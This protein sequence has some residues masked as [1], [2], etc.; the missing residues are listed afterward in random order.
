MTIFRIKQIPNIITTSRLILA[1]PIY[2]LVLY[3]NYPAV[4][5]LAL[6]AGLSDCAD[7]WLA[8]KL[9]ALSR[10]GAIA[11]PLSD[12][13]MLIC[14][15]IA[16]VQVEQIPWWLAVVIVA[17]DVV[18]VSGAFV[19]HWLFG[20]YEMAPTIFGKANTCAQIIFALMVLAHQV[21]PVFPELCF[22]IGLWLLIILAFVS[23]GHYVYIWG[24][25][26]VAGLKAKN[27]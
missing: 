9:D 24:K 12:K 14:V 2:L 26:T 15:Y 10:Y 7:G 13:I 8:R 11:D 25:K 18:I 16:L 21:Y 20:R 19:Y 1:A 22:T 17:R 3:E 4:L 5:W 23:G 27:S 6:I